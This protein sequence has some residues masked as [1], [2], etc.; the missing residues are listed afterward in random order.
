MENDPVQFKGFFKQGPFCLYKWAFCKRFLLLGIGFYKPQKCKFVFQKSPSETPFKPDRVSSCTPKLTRP[1]LLQKYSSKR[2]VWAPLFCKITKQSPYK[3]N[4]FACSLA[5]RDKPV[6]VT[7]ERK[8]SG[9]ISFVIITKII[10]II[11]VPRNYFVIISARMVHL[12]LHFSSRPWRTL[13]P[14]WVIALST[15]RPADQPTT[16]RSTWTWALSKRKPYKKFMWIGVLWA[17]LRVAMW[18]IHVGGK[19][20]HGLLEESLSLHLHSEIV[21]E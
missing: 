21:W 17:G 16:R 19:F 13:P 18:I 8:C 7:L 9:G 2:I 11:I 4:S 6:A 1:K 15:W 14:T 5:N 20:R 3:A 12:R 10:T